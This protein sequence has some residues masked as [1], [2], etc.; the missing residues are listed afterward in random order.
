M[1]DQVPPLVRG[2]LLLWCTASGCRDVDGDGDEA[3]QP[4]RGPYG[5]PRGVPPGPLHTQ[6]SGCCAFVMMAFDPP[7]AP[8]TSLWNV[9][10]MASAL[11]QLSAYPLVVLTN[12]S[13]FPDGT[14]AAQGLRRLGVE[15]LPVLPVPVPEA[16]LS[17]PRAMPCA[18]R[19]PPSCGLQFLKLQV[20]R[21]TQF[22]RL[23][24]MDS[25]AILTSSV[26]RLFR[27]AGT[28]AQQDNWDCGSW[29]SFLVRRSPVLTRAVDSLQRRL[30][31]P[32]EVRRQSAGACSG[33]LLL[34]PSE[35]TYQ[36]LIDFMGTLNSAPGGDQEVIAR[37][38]DEVLHEPLKLLK[39]STASFGQCLGKTIPGGGISAFVH[40][41][42]WENRCFRLGAE[43]AE[44]RSHPLGRY[45]H[46]HFCR[47]SKAA[48]ISGASLS[49]FCMP[50]L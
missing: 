29:L 17:E 2:V 32:A 19:T 30:W 21:L 20:W 31:A 45:W 36:G 7:G 35:A 38:F 6:R 27:Q 25:D 33:M 13:R 26:D 12:A 44:C 11:R 18:E 9:L 14:D 49:Q 43:A 37:F 48:A 41:S 39:T 42:D 40:K 50:W 10:P 22:E 1:P 4:G 24:W 16:L 15:P 47:A 5:G 46:D 8:Q 34:E 28:W 3:L 23:I